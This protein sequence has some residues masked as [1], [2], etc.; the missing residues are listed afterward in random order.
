MARAAGW[1]PG[2]GGLALANVRRTLLFVRRTFC[3]TTPMRDAAYRLPAGVCAIN[4]SA[5]NK[6]GGQAFDNHRPRHYYTVAAREQVV[7]PAANSG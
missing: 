1:G 7:C 2:A 5:L 6:F 4:G 3:A